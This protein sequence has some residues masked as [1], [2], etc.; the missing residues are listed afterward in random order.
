MAR[1]WFGNRSAMKK[2][3][4]TG[5]APRIAASMMSRMKP[6]TRESSVKPPTVRMRSSIREVSVSGRFLPPPL[7]AASGREEESPRD[8]PFDG[9]DDAVL[10][11]LVEI[12]V[13]RQADDLA[14]DAV[15]NWQPA[16][17]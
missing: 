4:A 2:A 1:K 12:G 11:R 8:R 14:G 9:L 17:G 3:S 10:D 13:H 5:P 15:G 7:A 16:L 6:V